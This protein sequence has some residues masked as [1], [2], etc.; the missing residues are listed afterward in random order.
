MQLPTSLAH[1]I[2]AILSSAPLLLAVPDLSLHNASLLWGPYRPNLYLGLR[3]RVPESLLMGLMWGKLDAGDEALRHTCEI[4]DNMS[5]YGWTTYDTRHGGSQ[6]IQDQGNSIDITTEFVKRHE[7]P[8]AGN[9][10]LRIRGTPRED[11]KPGTKMRV[12]FYVGMEQDL[13]KCE[14]CQL[15]AVAT[16]QGQGDDLYVET[17]DIHMKHPELGTAEIRIPSP[18]FMSGSGKLDDMVVKSVKVPNTS[19]L[20]KTKCE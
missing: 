6:T 2:L 15:D 9:W 8:N 16:N 20:W 10:G 7:G 4:A 14:D 1:A 18:R 12:V 3:P 19:P 17:V 5:S 11:A 13:D